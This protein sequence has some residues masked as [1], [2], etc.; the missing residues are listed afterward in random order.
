MND[1]DLLEKMI[2]ASSAYVKGEIS[3][4]ECSAKMASS[5]NAHK[6]QL[7]IACVNRCASVIPTTWLDPLLTGK[8]AALTGEA[9]KWGCPDI[10]N[11]LKAIKNR[12]EHC[13]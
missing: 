10:E 9:G 4:K 5:L 1:Y 8:D 12:I 11:L 3:S 6:E 7:N 13:G 2:E